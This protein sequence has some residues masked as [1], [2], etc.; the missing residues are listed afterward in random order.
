MKLEL[1]FLGKTRESYLRAGIDDYHSRLRH[2]AKTNIVVLKEKKGS[3]TVAQ[4]KKEEGRRLLARG[5][6]ASF[7]VALDQKGKQISSE[8]LAQL[9]NKWEMRGLGTVC[10][11]IGGPFGLSE[12]VLKKADFILS[13]SKMTLT[14]EMARLLLLEQLYRA[15]SIKFGT[16]Y[17]K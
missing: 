13:F 3:G 12:E 7:L 10:F 11:L 14:H 1:L 2:Y 9:V 16:N 8:E 6:K 5:G 17:H 4:Q 15:Y